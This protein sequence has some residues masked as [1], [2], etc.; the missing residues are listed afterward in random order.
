MD[1]KY[2]CKPFQIKQHYPNL[3]YSMKMQKLINC[4]IQRVLNNK[5]NEKVDI[6]MNEENEYIS[7]IF[8]RPKKRENPNDTKSKTV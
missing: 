5:N 6:G 7:N 4:E 8:I 3:S 2:N 1:I